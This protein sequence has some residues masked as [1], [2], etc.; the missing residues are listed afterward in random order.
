M[1]RERSSSATNQPGSGESCDWPRGISRRTSPAA[2]LSSSGCRLE[3]A[4]LALKRVC[5]S[6]LRD[7]LGGSRA[8]TAG[9]SGAAD[10]AG[11]GTAT[12]TATVTGG[13]AAIGAGGLLL[14]GATGL[15]AAV[16][17]LAAGRAGLASDGRGGL[18]G[19]GRRRGFAGSA[20]LSL[21]LALPALLLF[22]NSAARA[23]TFTP[24]FTPLAS[25]CCCGGCSG[26]GAG[27]G[28]WW[29]F[30]QRPSTIP[31][32]SSPSLSEPAA[33][34][35]LIDC[36]LVWLRQRCP[37]PRSRL[38]TPES[39]TSISRVFMTPPSHTSSR[40]GNRRDSGASA[41]DSKVTFPV[42]CN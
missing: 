41:R 13:A 42:S 38:P 24:A 14:A 32:S 27:G 6:A 25:C 16:V 15:A 28:V 4:Y 2:K 5:A 12:A 23:D 34:M 22:S 31:H 19:K 10:G 21:L 9:I 20:A 36:D 1:R 39:P 7:R 29:S 40:I 11:T 30:C 3:K 35:A 18:C 8:G 37:R 17:A 33:F 26:A